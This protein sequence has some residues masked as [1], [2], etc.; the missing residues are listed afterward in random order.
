MLWL[1]LMALNWELLTWDQILNHAV[2]ENEGERGPAHSSTS[3][4]C[5]FEPGL[6][7]RDKVAHFEIGGVRWTFR[8]QLK[9]DTLLLKG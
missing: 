8:H 9:T 6:I 4:L 2:K 5:S 7:F 1:A 3:V